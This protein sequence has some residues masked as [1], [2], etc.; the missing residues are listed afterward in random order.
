MDY[1]KFYH[2]WL[3]LDIVQGEAPNFYQ[4]LGLKNMEPDVQKI[5]DAFRNTL[6]CLQSVNGMANPEAY[7]AIMSRVLEA[8]K[9][10][11]D[12]AQKHDYDLQLSASTGERVWKG[13][14]RPS[15]LTRLR[16]MSLIA[17]S[18]ILGLGV[19][20]VMALSV[21]R[22]PD[23]SIIFREEA[24]ARKVPPFSSQLD[25]VVYRPSIAQ[26][27]QPNGYTVAT[28]KPIFKSESLSTP[29]SSE[30]AESKEEI[31]ET[32]LLSSNTSLENQSAQSEIEEFSKILSN[33]IAAPEKEET[34]KVNRRSPLYRMTAALN[35]DTST[36]ETA[37]TEPD[38]FLADVTENTQDAE[39]TEVAGDT[40]VA[41]VAEDDSPKQEKVLSLKTWIELLEKV[42]SSMDI[43]K[44]GATEAYALLQYQ[45]IMEVLQK[46]NETE[47]A[48]DP[49]EIKE[50]TEYTLTV[51]KYLGKVKHFD[52]AYKLCDVMQDF[53][54]KREMAD[55]DEMANQYRTVIQKYQS[56]YN[57]IQNIFEELKKKPEDPQLNM[58]YALWIWQ[59]TGKIEDSIPYLLH[60]T[61]AKLRKVASAEVYIA[62]NK[63][64]NTPQATLQ[65]ADYWWSITDTLPEKYVPLVKEHAKEL[66]RKVD[67]SLL[68]QNQKER[69]ASL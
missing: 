25:Y 42:R 24:Q 22:N 62:Q 39:D 3:Q 14:E 28:N 35:K 53:C 5:E 40:E 37:G 6:D 9:V 64:M 12:P 41:K 59:D 47:S 10:F 11:S 23:G 60:C 30:N 51:S 58:Q 21:E 8:H 44:P 61:H 55:L 1:S 69:I 4:I 36:K 56:V 33:E 49:E 18:F 15:L 50:F 57:E 34:A 13:Y 67:S 32:S 66:Y 54:A 26:D 2:D 68:S 38:E 19:M 46:Q 27:Y 16:Q 52:E 31:Q 20:V 17:F 7:T 63:E 48:S 43:T 29:D 65:I 45:T